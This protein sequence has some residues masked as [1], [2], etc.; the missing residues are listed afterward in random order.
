MTVLA[1]PC[2][3]VI[4]LVPA[5]RAMAILT[6]ILAVPV[7]AVT[8]VLA[9]DRVMAASIIAGAAVIYAGIHLLVLRSGIADPPPPTAVSRAELPRIVTIQRGL[10]LYG[11]L[12]AVL[13]SA[14]TYWSLAQPSQAATPVGIIVAV[15]AASWFQYRRAL[16]MERDLQG[17]LYVTQFGWG[18]KNRPAYVVRSEPCHIPGSPGSARGSR[19]GGVSAG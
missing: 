15:L 17:E 11:T 10:V 7:V 4:A 13:C 18:K 16:R 1:A 5:S 12:L 19:T 6:L 2:K 3:T 14:A 8:I 9:T